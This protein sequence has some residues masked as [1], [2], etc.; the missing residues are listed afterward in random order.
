MRPIALSS[1]AVAILATPTVAFAH[2]IRGEATDKSTLE[3]VPLG[4]EHMLLGWDHL[5]FVLGI[6]L[7]AGHPVRAAKL[8]S[9]FVAGHSVTLVTA[10][11]FEWRVSATLVDVVI[12]L[13]VVFV[14]VLGLR[15]RPDDFLVPGAIIF[16]LGLVH[17]FGLATRLQDL[18]IPDDGLVGKTIAFNVGI[19]L[20]QLIAVAVMVAV[21]WSAAK[22][23]PDWAAARRGA[24]AAIAVAG[25]V[26]AALLVAT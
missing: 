20:G 16:A 24:Y 9:L 23:L 10:T 25:S 19:E 22:R 5:L 11:I 4:V 14:A 13:S 2:G 26:G 7:L 1:V 12:A 3:Y 17:G 21:V 6:V 8:I 18:G 15:G